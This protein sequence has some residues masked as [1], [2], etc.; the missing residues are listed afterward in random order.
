MRSL[1]PCVKVGDVVSAEVANLLPVGSQIEPGQPHINEYV[2]EKTERGWRASDDGYTE[3]TLS[4]TANR[5]ILRIGP[6]PATTDAP[7]KA[8]D[9]ITDASKKVSDFPL[10][11]L[12]ADSRLRPLVDVVRAAI[13]GVQHNPR[14]VPIRIM[15]A[16]DA[17]P[18]E[19]RAAEST[20]AERG[21]SIQ[22]KPPQ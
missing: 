18:P 19:L 16:V 3:S 8:E 13:L 11:D 20:L 21:S 9:H 22:S 5:R 15:Q 2:W 17:L 7:D 10:A 6:A 4:S 1:C 12:L 14:H